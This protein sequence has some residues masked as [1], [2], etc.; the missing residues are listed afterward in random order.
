[1]VKLSKRR[2]VFE[3]KEKIYYEGPEPGT[4]IQH[5]KDTDR[6][7]NLSVF[8]GTAP[9]P[10]GKGIFNNRISELLMQCLNQV[11]ITTH[12]IR[13]LNMREQLVQITESVPLQAVLRNYATADFAK[14]FSLTEGTRLP[15]NLIE[16]HYK[17]LDSSTPVNTDYILTFGWATQEEMEAIENLCL[18]A[19][20][21]LT[22]YFMGKNILLG[23]LKLEF[24]RYYNAL[25]DEV[26][27]V[28][29]NEILPDSCQLWDL[30]ALNSFEVKGMHRLEYQEVARRLGLLKNFPLPV[31][32]S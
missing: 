32:E 30:E 31:E 17:T 8:D 15:R 25:I 12:F 18:R 9:F 10:N 13:S 23:E 3:A 22:G 1:M 7:G 6:I 16:F 21:F 27:I 4:L 28:L 11:G 20:D 5:F 26:Q 29:T 2:Q 24:G 14:K 19:N